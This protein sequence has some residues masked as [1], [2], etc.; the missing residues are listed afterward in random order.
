[1]IA[2]DSRGRPCT[3]TP[4]PTLRDRRLLCSLA[5]RAIADHAIMMQSAMQTLHAQRQCPHAP[6]VLGINLNPAFDRFVRIRTSERQLGHGY[7]PSS[8]PGAVIQLFSDR[9]MGEPNEMMN[10][11]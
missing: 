7:S 2:A 1:M 6:R 5:Q 8:T 10:V 11:L 9:R 4:H 3:V